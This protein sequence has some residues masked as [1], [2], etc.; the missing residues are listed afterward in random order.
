M[1]GQHCT[2]RNQLR[3]YLKKAKKKKT[4]DHNAG[5]NHLYFVRGGVVVPIS[6]FTLQFFY[7]AGNGISWD[8]RARSAT[9]VGPTTGSNLVLGL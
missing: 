8:M 9:L 3:S 2:K 4:M 7:N 5:H 1:V 6:M